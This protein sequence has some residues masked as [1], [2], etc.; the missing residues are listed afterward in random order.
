M[1]PV[2]YLAIASLAIMAAWSPAVRAEEAWPLFDGCHWSFPSLCDL[3]RQRCCWAPDDYCRKHL[4]CPPP[5]VG[6]CIDD[7][8]GKCLPSVPCNLRGCVD[9]Y[10]SKN[11]PIL[12]PGNCDPCCTPGPKVNAPSCVGPSGH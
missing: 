4:P 1:K 8:H 5:C 10:C 11:C 9:D 7:Y 12:L 6:G 3:W 2:L